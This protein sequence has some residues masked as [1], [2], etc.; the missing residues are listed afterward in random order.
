MPETLGAGEA[1][2]VKAGSDLV[3]QLHYTTDGR[4]G[5]DVSR[6]GLVFCHEKPRQRVFMLAAA[7]VRFV[8]PA[9]NPDVVLTSKLVL[10]HEASL[11]SLLPHMH[12]RGKSFE[13]RAVF[14][15]GERKTLLRVPN[16]NYNWQ[17][18]YYLAERLRLP[19]D[20][21]IEC[22]AHYDNSPNNPMNPDPAATVRF[23]PQSSDEMMI[24]YFEVAADPEVDLRDLLIGS[25]EIDVNRTES[26]PAISTPTSSR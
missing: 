26:R 15:N 7:N 23:G 8:I 5:S 14:P 4:P 18:S 11:V 21:S 13:F 19:A 12:L 22:V 9:G 25:S 1:K 6:A 24:G 16:Y 3:F 20:T 17:L 10:H 2:L